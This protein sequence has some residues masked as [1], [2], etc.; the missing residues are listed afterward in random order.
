MSRQ[1]ATKCTLTIDGVEADYPVRAHV[2]V[3]YGLGMG[4]GIGAQLDGD[5]DALVDG[6]WVPVDEV[7]PG[8]L[9]QATESLEELALEDD[10]DECGH[11][12]EVTS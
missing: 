2:L 6:E 4:G 5:V 3:E 9:A 8:D 7:A 10:S 12:Y 1:Y 11:E